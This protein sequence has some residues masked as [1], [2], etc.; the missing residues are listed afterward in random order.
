MTNSIALK[1]GDTHSRGTETS[2]IKDRT[3]RAAAAGSSDVALRYVDSAQWDRFAARFA[4]VV[5]EQTG[6]FLE[7]RWGASRTEC[8][9]VERAGSDIGGAAVVVFRLPGTDRGLAIVKWGP[10]WRETG[11]PAD[12]DRL[13]AIVQAIARDYVG[14]RRCFLSILPHADPEFGAQT[15]SV[16]EELGFGKGTTLPYPDRY[17]VNVSIPPEELKSSLDQKW[18]YNLKKSLKGGLEVRFADAEEGYSIFMDLYRRM[19]GRKKFQDSSA[20]DTLGDMIQAEEESHRPI[21]VLVSHQGQPTAGAVLSVGG[22]RAVYL[23]GA[24]DGRA[25]RLRAGYAMHWWIAEWL[26]GLPQVKWYDLGGTD[27]C[28]GLRQFKNGL[29]GKQGQVVAVPP[30]HNLSGSRLEHLLGTSIYMARDLKAATSQAL[31]RVKRSLSP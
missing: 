22:E 24:T 7:S 10:L 19:L 20:I 1:V 3:S 31:H 18:R 23:Y 25:L 15:V 13:R 30:V 28:S 26:S 6:S 21:F 2:A 11:K 29:C 8:V 12:A 4:D 27:G 5:S 9:I 17:L 16:L 14:R